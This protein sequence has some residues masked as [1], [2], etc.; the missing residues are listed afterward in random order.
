MKSTRD[1]QEQISNS[2]RQA[3]LIQNDS[4]ESQSDSSPREM[5]T[6]YD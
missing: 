1:F 2:Q 3:I 4:E 6:L 5:E